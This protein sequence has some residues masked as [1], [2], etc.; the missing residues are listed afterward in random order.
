MSIYVPDSTGFTI[1]HLD[2]TEPFVP[3]ML[4]ENSHTQDLGHSPT[5]KGRINVQVCVV[6][7]F[8]RGAD[9]VADDHA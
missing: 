6:I 8:H 7:D 9:G 4:T 5:V 2:T 1:S 3:K